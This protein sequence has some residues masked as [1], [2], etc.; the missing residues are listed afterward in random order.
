MT[1][2]ILYIT[3][4]I[5]WA[6]FIIFGLLLLAGFNIPVSEDLML[7]TS[8]VLA[9]KN[10]DYFY[11]LLIGVF[12][13]AY[14]SDLIAYWLGRTLGPKLWDIKIFANMVSKDKIKTVSSYYEKYGVLTL[15]LGRFIP[16]GVRNA[17][18]ITAGLGKMN[19]TKFALSDLLA[20]TISTSVFFP[21]YYF[22]GEGV[23]EYV[24]KGNI[25]LF[26]IAA[27]TVLTLL[28]LKKKRKRV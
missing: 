1:D 3:Q 7:F 27:I 4:H 24:K 11:Q 16:F 12:L 20:C 6:P 14:L 18:F 21:L 22:F 2:I 28:F 26:S 8:A 5:S 23:I 15:I 9:V 17:L 25:I 10:P 19:F 13:G